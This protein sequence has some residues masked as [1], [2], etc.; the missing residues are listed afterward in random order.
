[1]AKGNVALALADAV[2]HEGGHTAERRAPV[3]THRVLR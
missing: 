1:M 3:W 2:V